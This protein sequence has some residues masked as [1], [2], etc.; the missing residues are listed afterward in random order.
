MSGGISYFETP[1][2][3]EKRRGGQGIVYLL[4][5]K[6]PFFEYLYINTPNQRREHY[7]ECQKKGAFC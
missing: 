5:L 6:V 4:T 1:G 2:R 3:R 7:A